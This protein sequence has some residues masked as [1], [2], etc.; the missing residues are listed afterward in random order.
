MEFSERE[1]L[2]CFGSANKCGKSPLRESQG[3]N[4]CIQ[5]FSELGIQE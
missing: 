3:K 2:R 4:E 1:R 5:V